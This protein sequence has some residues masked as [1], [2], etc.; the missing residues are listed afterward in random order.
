M[1][2]GELQAGKNREQ[3]ASSF[4]INALWKTLAH[5]SVTIREGPLPGIGPPSH[6]SSAWGIATPPTSSAPC[7][8]PRETAPTFG[9][10]RRRPGASE[11]PPTLT[12]VGGGEAA[13]IGKCERIGPRTRRLSCALSAAPLTMHFLAGASTPS[14]VVP[15]S[16]HL[17]ECVGGSG[18]RHP[19]AKQCTSNQQEPERNPINDVASL[20]PQQC[21]RQDQ[22]SPPLKLQRRNSAISNWADRIPDRRRSPAPPPCLPAGMSS[23]AGVRSIMEA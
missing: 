17:R 10:L 5:M 7:P 9:F 6:K 23:H 12:M 3:E 19:F 8:S 16:Q 11:E 18:C 20:R 14:Q 22:Y 15:P 2:I 1:V 21:R 4:C 13:Y